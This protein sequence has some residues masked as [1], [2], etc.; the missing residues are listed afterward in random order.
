MAQFIRIIFKILKSISPNTARVFL[1]NI[2]VKGP[3]TKYDGTEVSP[4][5]YQYI[6]KHLINLEKTLW[7]LELAGTIIATEKSQFVMAGLKIVGWVCDYDGQHSDEV[8]IAKIL[9]WPVPVNVPELHGFVGLTVYFQVLIDKFQWI[10]KPLY[11]PLCKGT[12]F[13]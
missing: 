2:G 9:D 7:F 11:Y 8:K 13:F 6:F 12:K 1:D 5:L 4:S 3:K 10:M